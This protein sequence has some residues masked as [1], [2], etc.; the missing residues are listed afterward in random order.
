MIKPL[1]FVVATAL[2]MATAS[3]QAAD[4]SAGEEKYANACAQCHG[5]SG[6]GMASFPALNGRDA[7]YISSRLE[8]YR[9]GEEVGSNS[10]LMIPNASDLS[11]DEIANL[12]AYISENFE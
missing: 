8:T 6:K 10:S 11:D 5:K 1:F 4:A 3:V 2:S 9:A 7:D 12:A